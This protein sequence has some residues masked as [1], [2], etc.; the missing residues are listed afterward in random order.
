MTTIVAE[1]IEWRKIEAFNR[2][3]S[4]VQTSKQAPNRQVLRR[5]RSAAP[6]HG[7]HA[8]RLIITPTN[9]L[10]PRRRP[11]GRVPHGRAVA[12]VAER[13]E[14]KDRPGKVGPEPALLLRQDPLV[15][16]QRA[17]CACFWVKLPGSHK[18][19]DSHNRD[20]KKKI[21]NEN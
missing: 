18:R 13:L 21:L 10:N 3:S 8:A 5:R 6:P 19:G 20:D 7:I 11:R 2:S 4:S 9:A 17:F 1:A 12:K 14:V 16:L 15:R